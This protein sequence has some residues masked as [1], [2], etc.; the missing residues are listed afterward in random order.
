MK[1]TNK[2]TAPVQEKLKEKFFLNGIAAT[3]RGKAFTITNGELAS[4]P[5]KN[6]FGT[7]I[8]VKVP[9]KS[10]ELNEYTIYLERFAGTIGKTMFVHGKEIK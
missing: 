2:K 8:R 9:L 4:E 1:K 6:E 7:K 5:V 3:L 10:G